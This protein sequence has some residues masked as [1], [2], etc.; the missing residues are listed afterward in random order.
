MPELILKLKIDT[1]KLEK[2]LFDSIKPI[3]QKISDNTFNSIPVLSQKIRNLTRDIFE[4]GTMIKG[5]LSD[6]SSPGN[7]S[8]RGHFGIDDGE[9][10]HVAESIVEIILKNL[11][12]DFSGYT[13]VGRKL[14]GRLTILLSPNVYSDLTSADF[15]TVTTKKGVNLPWMEW[16]F[17]AGDNPV[18]AE[19]RIYATTNRKTSRSGLA[20]MIRP[21]DGASFW[22]VPSEVSG[23]DN[24]N[25]ITRE[26]KEHR[27]EYLNLVQTAL[28]REFNRVLK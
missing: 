16:T 3:L 19:Y 24:D 6:A 1:T 17:K 21:K 10:H 2:Y 12:V 5:L 14:S 25:W 18:I 23:T 27:N 13:L 20:I 28:Q 4:D 11:Y 26:L 8:L 15:A 9:Q 7:I 22:K